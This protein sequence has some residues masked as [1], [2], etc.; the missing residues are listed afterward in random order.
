MYPIGNCVAD[1][2][3]SSYV[4]IPEIIYTANISFLSKTRPSLIPTLPTTADLVSDECIVNAMLLYHNMYKRRRRQQ[5]PWKHT[6]TGNNGWADYVSQSDYAKTATSG[7]AGGPASKP[8]TK[9]VRKAPPRVGERRSLRTCVQLKSTVDGTPST[10]PDAVEGSLSAVENKPVKSA[11]VVPDESKARGKSERKSFRKEKHATVSSEQAKHSKIMNRTPKLTSVVKENS[12]QTAA[13]KEKSKNCNIDKTKQISTDKEKSKNNLIRNE[14]LEL[15][16]VSKKKS[17]HSNLCNDKPKNIGV[18]K[19]NVNLT[20]VS[21][22]KVNLTSVGKKKVKHANKSKKNSKYS[23]KSSQHSFCNGDYKKGSSKVLSVITNQ[24]IIESLSNGQYERDTILIAKL[25]VAEVFG[26]QMTDDESVKEEATASALSTTICE[27]P[28]VP[29]KTTETTFQ[30]PSARSLV[31]PPAPTPSTLPSASPA[32]NPEV[33]APATT[34]PRTPARPAP[35]SPAP[36]RSASRRECSTSYAARSKYYTAVFRHR[37]D[38][39]EAYSSDFGEYVSDCRSDLNGY[40]TYYS[41]GADMTSD[42]DGDDGCEGD[43]VCD[44]GL[45]SG[46]ENPVPEDLVDNEEVRKDED[47]EA[48]EDASAKSELAFLNDPLKL[49]ELLQTDEVA[50]MNWDEDDGAEMDSETEKLV[51]EFHDYCE[52]NPP[53]PPVFC[54]C[55]KPSGPPGNPAILLKTATMNND[56]VSSKRKRLN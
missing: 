34:S 26:F 37:F 23:K 16:S 39:V 53:I 17:I 44:V 9:R 33:V 36:T 22:K 7:G 43:V 13:G 50:E 15:N 28:P 30:A 48:V 45:G 56:R 20:S 55:E 54:K 52:T 47:E 21:K 35:A 4:K 12:K 49:R 46:V 14:E 40:S 1:I 38:S 2:L 3:I 8:P 41:D 11:T 10:Q 5:R 32:P 29:F 31:V 42:S 19:K 18:S 24:K 25:I 51:K 6:F 27:T